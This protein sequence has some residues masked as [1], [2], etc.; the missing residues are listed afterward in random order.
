[1][2]QRTQTVSPEVLEFWRRQMA[3]LR[4]RL[5]ESPGDEWV[6]FWVI[7]AHIIA[8]LL[9]RYAGQHVEGLPELPA[10]PSLPP[11]AGAPTKS[12]L[13]A[14]HGPASV[15]PGMGK[16]PRSGEQIRNRLVEIADG[17]RERY[18]EFYR[19]V[20]EH[21]QAALRALR[22]G[23]DVLCRV[24]PREP[25]ES[26]AVAHR[27]RQPEETMALRLQELRRELEADRPDLRSICEAITG[28]ELSAAEQ[29]P[30]MQRMCEELRIA[31]LFRPAGSPA[32]EDELL[33]ELTNPPAANQGFEQE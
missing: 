4:R 16:A 25:A 23:I 22:T 7:Q 2:R 6:W 31:D 10:G 21:R 15:P 27:L 1:M 13:P 5:A 29:D 12:E 33:R 9:G 19:M 32:S 8:Y 20:E 17:N 11:L 3:A 24:S 30:A 28:A 18:D 26:S 14:G